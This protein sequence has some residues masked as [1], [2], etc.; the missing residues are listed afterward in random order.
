MNKRTG[1][2]GMAWLLA[3]AMAAGSLPSLPAQAAPETVAGGYEIDMEDLPQV[4]FAK[5]KNWEALYEK[6]WQSHKNNIKKIT[7]GLNPEVIKDGDA[8]YVDEAFDGTIF[9]WDTLL[10]MMFDKYGYQQFP[11]LNSMDNFY[12]H[13]VDSEGEDDGYI[14]RRINESNGSWSYGDYR[15]VDAI[16]PPLFGWAE[17]EQYKIHGDVSR[18]TKLVKGKTVLERLDSFFQFLK[19]TRTHK[20]G[21][22]A[23]LYVSNGQGNGLDNTPNQDWGGWGQAAN[24]MSIQQV[25]AAHYI[26]RIAREVVEKDASLTEEEKAKYKALAAKYDQEEADL[27]ALVQEK[28]WD[29]EDGFYY[30]LNSNGDFTSIATPTGLWSLSAGIPSEEQA[31]RM[32]QTFTQNSEKMFR[33]NGLA[34]VCYDYSTFKSTGGYWNG[35][36]WSPTSYVWIKGLQ[37][38]GYEDLAFQEAVRHINALSDVYERGAYDRYGNELNTLWENYS[39]EYTKPGS[40]E[41]SDAEP[42][43][44]NFVGWTG[45]LAIGSMIEDIVGVTMDASENTVDWN[46]NLSEEHGVSGLYM[47]S[48]ENGENRISL[49]AKGRT[50]ADAELTVEVTCEKPFILNLS[51]DERSKAIAVEAGTHTYTLEGTAGGEKAY[52]G[53]MA[54][55]YEN[56]G[57]TAEEAANARDYVYFT[58]QEDNRITDGLKNQAGKEADFIYNVNTVGNRAVSRSSVTYEPDEQLEEL[59]FADA[60]DCVRTPYSLGEDGFMFMVPADK[61]MRTVKAIVGVQNAEAVVNVQMSDGSSKNISQVL[62]AG[63]R[64]ETYVVEIPYRAASEG[65]N[66][67]VEYVITSDSGSIRLKGILAEDGGRI[68]AGQPENFQVESMDGA[69]K[70]SA[71]VPEEE[72]FGSWRIYVSRDGA[73]TLYET[74]S[75]PYVVEGLE[76]DTRYE[77]SVAGVVNGEE[78]RHTEKIA[79]VPE[80][81]ART[82]EERARFD[83]EKA[84]ALVLNGN[85]DADHIEKSLNFD[86]EGPVYG[87]SISITSSTAEERYGVMENGGI[88]SPIL[89]MEDIPV[90]LTAKVTLGETNV[91]IKQRVT[92]AAKG[93]N[94]V[95]CVIGSKPDKTSGEIN[96]TE[97]GS[98]D[99]IQFYSGSVSDY[100]KKAGEAYISEIRAQGSAYRVGDSPF[101]FVAADAGEAQ[102]ANNSSVGVRGLGNGFSF[103]VPYSE[104]VQHV[105]V[106]PSVW[107]G[108]VTVEME[109]NGVTMYSDS[110]GRPDT[111]GGMKG[112]AFDIAY[113]MPSEADEAI[114]K[115]SCSKNLD[116]QWGGCVVA[117]AAVTLRETDETITPPIV[118]EEPIRA[119]LDGQPTKL[120]LTEEGD[121]DWILFNSTDVNQIERKAG[122]AQI[123]DL[124]PLQAITKL[125]TSSTGMAINYT[126][127]TIKES[128]SFDKASVY[129]KLGNGITF[130]APYSKTRRDLDVYFGAWSAKTEIKLE[131]LKDGEPVEEQ[132]LEHDTGAQAGGT[133]AVYCRL[134]VRYGGSNGDALRVTVQNGALYDEKWGNTCIQAITLAGGEKETAAKEGLEKVIAMAEEILALGKNYEDVEALAAAVEAGKGIL[135]DANASQED[136]DNAA[137]LILDELSKLAKTADIASLESLIKAAENLLAGK[138][139]SGSLE[140]L[141]KA[142][143][144]AKAVAADQ[145]RKDSDISDA[146]GSL[147][148]AI[149]Q[150]E[151]KGDKA[152]LEAMLVKAGQILAD[153]DAYVAETVE[154]L[155][156]A[157]AE[158]Q[159]VSDNEDAAQSDIDE[160]VKALTRKV[161][162]ARLLGDVDG[163]GAVTTSDTAAVLRASAEIT[164]LSGTDAASADVNGDG[165]ADT[166]DAALILRYAAEKIKAF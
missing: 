89:P 163:D 8:W 7:A 92:V 16:N 24:D 66:M 55:S 46:V 38:Y 133:P 145:D 88:S 44:S 14:C 70:V 130:T 25:Q 104:K 93:E 158:A 152:A 37:E 86:V 128:G 61:E 48:Q 64:E 6:A 60:V 56:S 34:T 1:K 5:H 94:E 96:L 22:W 9:Q 53:M 107:A 81:T 99:W 117:L 42:S 134:H 155:A 21:K 102:P 19:R 12:A 146:Y 100:A 108:D 43:R 29:E 71:D 103:R 62:R 50:T 68:I 63:S 47:N 157:M 59:S 141:Q 124:L 52:L 69:L 132:I 28:M 77:V 20:D 129:E 39:S 136:V 118:E 79:Q 143:D 98:K 139:T 137:N 142:I 82:E 26:S 160:A 2:K 90:I 40:T 112:Q 84:F 91:T 11:T 76:N 87:S 105:T 4:H 95:P 138:Y 154:G 135:A 74:N 162:Q 45:A 10:M 36:M 153:K 27:K 164:E 125:G 114:V 30:N 54:K 67:L 83:W 65:Q 148:D 13:Q 97:E 122:G 126:D 166:S 73:E 109:I 120:N 106:Y 17:W 23:G 140:N 72:T 121:A 31:D 111:S 149:M 151:R 51:C 123:T 113:R 75:L 115:V 80:K 85:V 33:P 110:F 18:F 161:A 41:N 119:K 165:V 15:T 116:T 159:K 49:E 57:L 156:E 147:I 101:T 35:A 150:L 78:G 32:I 3:A 127:G 58:G 131:I 144:G